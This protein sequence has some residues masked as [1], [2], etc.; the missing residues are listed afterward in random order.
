[1]IRDSAE[2]SK[3]TVWSADW[4]RTLSLLGTCC[5]V[6]VLA[7][8]RPPLH[9]G[10][11]GH[12]ALFWL[13]PLLI[14]ARWGPRGSGALVAGMGTMLC[15]GMGVVTPAKVGGYLL[16]GAAIEAT[17]YLGR[18]AP[19]AVRMVAAGIGGHLGKLAFK[20]LLLAG[21]GLPMTRAE[22]HLLWALVLYASFGAAAALLCLGANSLVRLW[23]R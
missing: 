13:P 14:A 6:Y 1:M 7:L 3:N 10:L 20:V 12:S 4:V 19:E 17:Y 11:P 5:G 21:T 23:R 15:W 8:A 9:L 2:S 16:A 22:P 18:R